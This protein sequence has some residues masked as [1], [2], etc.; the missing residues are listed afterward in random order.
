MV[1][2]RIQKDLCRQT[3]VWLEANMYMSYP[4]LI[5]AK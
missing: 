4:L 1:Q 5:L 3:T 2:I